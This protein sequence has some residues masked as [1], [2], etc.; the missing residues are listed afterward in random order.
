MIEKLKKLGHTIPCYVEAAVPLNEESLK[1]EEME[2]HPRGKIP[3]YE[4]S[5]AKINGLQTRH[6][7]EVIGGSQVQLV[8]Q[9]S[10]YGQETI[11]KFPLTRSRAQGLH[12]WLEKIYIPLTEKV[13]G[14]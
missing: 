6:F 2:I 11:Q 5:S 7:I 12:R 9:V 14:E 8:K 3:R 1:G 13:Q 4:L 10:G